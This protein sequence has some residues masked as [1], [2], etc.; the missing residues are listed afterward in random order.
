MVIVKNVSLGNIR[1]SISQSSRFL[2]KAGGIDEVELP[3]EVKKIPFF[4]DLVKSGDLV[5]IKKTKSN[6][7]DKADQDENETD[8]SESEQ[9]AK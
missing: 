3:D 5:V 2:I 8:Q 6:K 4:Q 7:Q 1:I 9:Q